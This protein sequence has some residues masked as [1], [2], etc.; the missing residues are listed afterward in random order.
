MTE[1]LTKH[2]QDAITTRKVSVAA[3]RLAPGCGK[4]FVLTRR[5][6]SHLE[7]G[8]DAA[9]LG[10]LVAITTSP[11]AAAQAKCGI[12]FG[13]R[14]ASG[15]RIA[16]NMK[17]PHWLRILYD[18]DAARIATIHSFCT[19]LLR[20]H[21]V[22]AGL[23]PRFAVTDAAQTDALIRQSSRST[24]HKLLEEQNEDVH[25]VVLH[26]GLERSQELLGDLI[27]QRLRV[28]P[29]D[30]ANITADACAATWPKMWQ[31]DLRAAVDAGEAAVRG[32]LP[33]RRATG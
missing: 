24:L 27:G 32:D 33:R 31:R 11:I 6:L 16:P 28:T 17:S 5:F 4:T 21:A 26:F 13:P 15:C 10:S 14:A 18:L 23:D 22:E 30:F 8:G 12:A 20:A 3:C 1:K 7:P 2:Q 29:D 19:S 25:L 9:K